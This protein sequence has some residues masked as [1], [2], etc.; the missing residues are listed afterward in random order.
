[1]PDLLSPLADLL[2]A[3]HLA[4]E[5]A[6]AERAPSGLIQLT[7]L[8]R[9]GDGTRV[10]AQRTHPVFDPD[11]KGETLLTDIDAITRHLEAAGIPTPRLLRRHDAAL[12]WRDA[13]GKLWRLMTHLPGSTF[14]RVERPAQ[15][16]EAARLCARFHAALSTLPHVFGFSRPGAHDTVA[17]LA[18]LAGLTGRAS[19]PGVSYEI[20]SLADEILA[21]AARRPM[22]PRTP[23]RITHGDLKISNVLFDDAGAA[24]AL[25][26]LDTIG[27]LPL[28]YELGDA[29]RSWCNPRGEDVT[30]TRFDLGIFTAAVQGYAAG[31]RA[32]GF[33]LHPDEPGSFVPGLVTIAL[34]LASRF[35]TDAFEDRYFGWDPTRFQSR[36]EHNRIR[37]EGQLV[38]AR[39]VLAERAAAERVV[40]DTFS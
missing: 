19:A 5:G 27:R 7:Y 8:V 24:H 17:H 37:A 40:V 25:I 3:F 39:A 11:G 28:A 16:G 6:T 20:R 2:A 30:A 21:E 29:L 23:A 13:E 4:P 26:D 1:M 18:R 22:L 34:E 15:A 38:L 31:A 35:C 32:A 10:V 36:R 9:L 33:V 14:D 12:G